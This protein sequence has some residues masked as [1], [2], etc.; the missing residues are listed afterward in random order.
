MATSGA[1]DPLVL[2][3]PVGGCRLGVGLVERCP[4]ARPEAVLS[5]ALVAAVDAA[6]RAEPAGQCP[7]G[8][9]GPLHPEHRRHHA[10]MVVARPA[11]WRPL[12]GEQRQHAPPVLLRQLR[13]T[14]RR[15]RGCRRLRH[16]EHGRASRPARRVPPLGDRLVASPPA[17]PSQPER[18]PLVRLSERQQQPAHLRRRQW[19]QLT[20]RSKAPL[21]PPSCSGTAVG[22][23]RVTSR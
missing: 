11:S 22:C 14:A 18:E 16:E 5:P 15:P 6:P 20:C 19:D 1:S 9:A 2:Q 23:A 7:P 3:R 8:A 10:P 4:D 17:R 12:R 13:A 21:F